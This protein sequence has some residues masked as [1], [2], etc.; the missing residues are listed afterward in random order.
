MD[1][2]EIWLL[3]IFLSIVC[4]GVIFLITCVHWNKLLERWKN[5]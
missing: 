3:S 1:F 5:G 4:I 2:P